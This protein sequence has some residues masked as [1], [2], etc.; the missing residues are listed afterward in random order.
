MMSLVNTNFNYLSTMGITEESP[1][2]AVIVSIYYVGCAIG[3]I[4]ASRYADKN[5]RKPS[6]FACL[7]TSCL[8]NLL[9]FLAGLG[10]SRGAL[11]VMLTGRFIMGL[12]VG[13]IDSV[14]PLYSSELHESDE[15]G[16]AL[17]Q[18][19]Q[20]NILGL[21]LAFGLNLFVTRKLGKSNQWA[22]RI[23]II[24]MQLFPVI[25]IAFI[26]RLPESPR[27]LVSKEKD[28]KA[29]TALSEIYDEGDVEDELKTLTKARDD[30]SDEKI[31]Y[32]DML[33]PQGS[34]F[35]PTMLTIMGQVNQALTG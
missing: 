32:S 19:F 14:V 8:G 16:K 23:P 10:Y 34:Q 31:G 30:A 1:L 17:A 29:K 21:N 2:V 33:S 7:V 15:R 26:S 12:G 25:L 27:W 35:H 9:M 4:L 22:W 24:A 13:G 18:E 11:F 6:M 5:G 20:A 28:E 3:A